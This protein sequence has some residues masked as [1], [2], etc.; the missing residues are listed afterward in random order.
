MATETIESDSIY[1]VSLREG[2]LVHILDSKRDDWWLVSTFPEGDVEAAE[3]WVEC[4]L[5]QHADCKYM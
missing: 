1:Q 3:G 5:L 4:K 2:Q